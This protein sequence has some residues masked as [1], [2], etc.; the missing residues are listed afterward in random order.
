MTRIKETKQLTDTER[1]Q[2]I[3][4]AIA[5][6]LKPVWYVPASWLTIIGGR[7]INRGDK[8]DGEVK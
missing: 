2:I 3:R 5:G 8:I 1:I 4:Q 6:K 7:D